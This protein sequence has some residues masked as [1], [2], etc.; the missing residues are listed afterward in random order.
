MS[1]FNYDFV[2]LCWN[3]FQVLVLGVLPISAVTVLAIYIK[4]I[5][6]ALGE[7]KAFLTATGQQH[8]RTLKRS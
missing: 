4:R 6:I 7:K 2:S 1:D 3:L 5:L 8:T